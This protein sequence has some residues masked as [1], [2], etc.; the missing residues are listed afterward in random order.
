MAFVKYFTQRQTFIETNTGLL[1][2]SGNSKTRVCCMWRGSGGSYRILD[3]TLTKACRY[4]Q[5]INIVQ[6]V[7]SLCLF[8]FK[9]VLI[10]FIYEV[11]LGSVYAYM[12]DLQGTLGW[13]RRNFLCCLE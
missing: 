6:G 1:A 7:I 2:K 5:K 12:R 3:T 4:K 9:L 13:H 11:E 10:I 8:P